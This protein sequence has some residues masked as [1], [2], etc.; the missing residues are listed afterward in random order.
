MMA[1]EGERDD[2]MPAYDDIEESP[3]NTLG[4]RYENRDHQ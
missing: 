2:L 4:K 1:E 3:S